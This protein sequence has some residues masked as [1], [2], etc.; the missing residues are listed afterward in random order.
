[1]PESAEPSVISMGTRKWDGLPLHSGY[2]TTI[3]GKDVETDSPITRG[4]MPTISGKSLEYE[5]EMEYGHKD[6]QDED[7][8]LADVRPSVPSTPVVRQPSPVKNAPSTSKPYVPPSSFYAQKPA[9]PKS[10][11]PL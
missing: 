7:S 10:A 1:M 5:N 9:K 4:E 2:S 8:S 11:A 3:G 6:V